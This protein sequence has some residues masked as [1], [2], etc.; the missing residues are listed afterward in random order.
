M[1]GNIII[2]I[3]FLITTTGNS[4]ST[5]ILKDNKME[6]LDIKNPNIEALEEFSTFREEYNDTITEYTKKTDRYVIN[7]YSN[8]SPMKVQ[9]IFFLDGNI[10]SENYRF[11]DVLINTT[12]KYD[13]KGNLIFVQNEEDVSKRSVSIPQLVEIIKEKYKVDLMNIE[14]SDKRFNVKYYNLKAPYYNVAIGTK[15]SNTFR[16][17]EVDDIT[18]NIIRDTIESGTK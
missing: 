2:I 17:I 13:N 10:A 11:Y 9:K 3:L 12:K 6:K 16:L 4:Q 15:G 18:G 8:S 7:Q 14:D 5:I 1:K